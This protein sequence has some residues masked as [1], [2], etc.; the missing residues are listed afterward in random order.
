MEKK[1]STCKEM[2]D[3]QE[4]GKRKTNP[5]GLRTQ[6]KLCESIAAK[7][8]RKNNPE[9]EKA[10]K[11]KYRNNP[12]NHAKELEYKKKYREEHKEEIKERARKHYLENQESNK[13]KAR[14]Y[15]EA[16][17]EKI[18]EA[19]AKYREENREAMNERN[20]GRTQKRRESDPFEM[21]KHR[22]RN[23]IRAGF[24]N[25]NCKKGN[26]TKD[27]LGCSFEFFREYIEAQFT[28][29]MSWERLSEI[30][31]DHI[32]PLASAKTEDDVIKLCHYT[33]YQPLWAL[34]NIRKS[35]KTIDNTQLKIL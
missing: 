25:K 13:E 28:D 12:A 30:H 3:G 16:N 24:K 11:A 32:I 26:K 33:N 18:K 20:R 35:D 19:A 21:F 7:K 5:D 15:R 27:I 29:G 8:W 23:N 9:K 2:K 4:F 31:L 10:R 14:L 22:I 6:C 34:D 17:S 1:C